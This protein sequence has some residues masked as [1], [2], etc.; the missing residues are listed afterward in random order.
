[1]I[2]SDQVAAHS[3]HHNQHSHSVGHS[4]RRPSPFTIDHLMAPYRRIVTEKLLDLT[5]LNSVASQMGYIVVVPIQR[6]VRRPFIHFLSLHF[7]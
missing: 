5:G 7:L 4:R 2:G 6:D 1:M 3:K